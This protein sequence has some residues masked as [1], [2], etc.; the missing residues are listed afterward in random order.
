MRGNFA[1]VNPFSVKMETLPHVQQERRP[2]EKEIWHDFELA[3]PHILGALME[4][5]THGLRALPEVRLEQLPRMA[6][7]ALWSTACETAF[8][9]AGGFLHAYNAN[10]RAAIE[11][12]VDADPVASRIRDIMAER[13]MWTGNA[14][15][16]LR[17]GA[18]VSRV[19]V[20]RNAAG[21]PKSPRALAGRLRRAQT[22]LRAL[23][24]EISFAREG[25]AG[26]RII[27]LRAL[28]A[29]SPANPT[30]TTVS[31]VGTVGFDKGPS[32]HPAKPGAC[33]AL[34]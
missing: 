2:A 25:R 29:A 9:P 3:R 19:G 21:W 12:V 4:A 23:G 28:R 17:V 31:T 22:P 18:D 5:A 10:R 20:S 15:D 33:R 13:T 7:F 26:T 11:D 14:S 6:D 1:G 8:C 34:I 32:S 30:Y 27:R 24:I 16:L